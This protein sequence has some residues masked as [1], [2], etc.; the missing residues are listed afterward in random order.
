MADIRFHN[1]SDEDEDNP[2]GEIITPSSPCPKC[3]TQHT[4]IIMYQKDKDT[5]HPA[6][7]IRN[8]KISCFKCNYKVTGNF[9]WPKSNPY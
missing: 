3:D 8:M 4:L 1:W 7:T 2:T 9:K 6:Y 5:G